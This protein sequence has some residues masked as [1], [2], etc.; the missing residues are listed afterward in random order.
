MD[1]AGFL[2]LQRWTWQD[3]AESTSELSL[4]V[5]E[6]LS[7]FGTVTF[8]SNIAGMASPGYLHVWAEGRQPPITKKRG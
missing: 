5:A 2:Y 3:L 1:S 8:C 6:E 4:W 7:R